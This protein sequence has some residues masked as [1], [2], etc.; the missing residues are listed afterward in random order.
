MLRLREAHH[1]PEATQPGSEHSLFQSNPKF[2]TP[3]P[4]HFPTISTHQTED[5]ALGEQVQG[6]EENRR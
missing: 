6:D 4:L 2:L 5:Q 3:E 1:L